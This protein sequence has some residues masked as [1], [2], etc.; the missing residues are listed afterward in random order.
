MSKKGFKEPKQCVLLPVYP[1]ILNRRA[2]FR[3]GSEPHPAL[4][5]WPAPYN[6]FP[7]VIEWIG[8]AL[9]KNS[10][11]FY[12]PWET[13]Q[14]PTAAALNRAKRL[15]QHSTSGGLHI[16]REKNKYLKITYKPGTTALPQKP[17]IVG[18]HELLCTWA[19]GNR[20]PG[21]R[22]EACHFYCDKA[23]CLAWR[24]LR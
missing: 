16:F 19:W 12:T 10:S 4:A 6:T 23:D 20:S 8:K 15:Y 22:L 14:Q 17:R 11:Y 24:H 18:L 1:D 9:Y 21:L 3:R 2:I 7:A 13:C 5:T